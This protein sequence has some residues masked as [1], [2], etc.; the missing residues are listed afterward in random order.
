MP[1]FRRVCYAAQLLAD[2]GIQEPIFLGEHVILLRRRRTRSHCRT[3]VEIQCPDTVLGTVYRVIN[4][5]RGQVTAEIP[6]LGTPLFTI[7][8]YLPVMESFGFDTE[9]RAATSGQAFP[10]TMFDHWQAMS[11]CKLVF[12]LSSRFLTLRTAPY[13]EGSKVAELVKGIRIR[14]GLKVRSQVPVTL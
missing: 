10:Q 14:K 7:R 3:A 5:R 9:L 2:P 8:A 1:G 6:R 13:D 4:K 12:L 11:G